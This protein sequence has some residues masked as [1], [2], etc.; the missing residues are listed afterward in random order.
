MHVKIDTEILKNFRISADEYLYLYL[1][2]VKADDIDDYD[3][4]I[5]EAKLLSEGLLKDGANDEFIVRA[6]FFNYTGIDQKFAE[7]LSHYPIKVG[8][9]ILRAKAIDAHEN[10]Q[11]K[12]KY[13]QI[14]KKNDHEDIIEGLKAELAMK[15]AGN[16]L[17]FMQR[18]TTWLNQRTWEKYQGLD[19]VITDNERR[20]TR[21]LT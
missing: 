17:E 9:R 12:K 14:L 15:K 21:K 2:H 1:L 3:L 7:L 20:N 4:N 18:L 13:E 10:Q 19:T 11:L 6:P 8:T 5:N 16:N